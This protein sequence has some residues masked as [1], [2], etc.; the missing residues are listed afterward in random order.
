VLWEISWEVS[1]ETGT[2]AAR[3]TLLHLADEILV[4]QPARLLVQRAVDGHHIALGNHLLEVRD[5]TAANLLLL[6]LRQGLVVVVE[7]LLAV[8]GLE[9]AQD[10]L[11]DAADGHGAD[12]LALE[13][14]LG[15]GRLGHVPVA[16]LDG[17]VGR[18]V[19]ADEHEDGHDDVLGHRHDVG[20]RHL[21][22]GDAAVCLVGGVEVDV[23]GADAG[24]DGQLEVLGLGEALG[25]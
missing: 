8:K 12:D 16:A 19:V 24:R 11:A 13:V 5:A 7:Q 3:L 25:C 20:A 22:H 4:K 18:V 21:G 9:A 2:G 1:G 10:A 23:V 15:L 14:V 6:L 17:L